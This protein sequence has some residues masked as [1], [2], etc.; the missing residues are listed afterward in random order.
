MKKSNFEKS[1]ITSFQRCHRNYVTE[2]RHQTKATRFFNLSPL[3]VKF[4][5]YANDPYQF[6]VV[7]FSRS[8]YTWLGRLQILF[9]GSIGAKINLH[10]F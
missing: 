3:P 10:I 5:C 4:S 7:V 9:E 6:H 1:V 2:K 8:S